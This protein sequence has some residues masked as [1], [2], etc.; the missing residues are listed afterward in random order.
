[1]HARCFFLF[2]LRKKQGNDNLATVPCTVPA[3]GKF[4]RT[5]S[6][7]VTV[8]PLREHSTGGNHGGT[9]AAQGSHAFAEGAFCQD[10]LPR[11]ESPSLT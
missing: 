4:G 10:G 9:E 6:V 8:Q 5:Y 11:W 1:M 3:K 7:L 2:R